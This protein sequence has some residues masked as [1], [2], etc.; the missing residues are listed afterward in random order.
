MDSE[1]ENLSKSSIRRGD[2][3]RIKFATSNPHPVHGMGTYISAIRLLAKGE[4]EL[5][6]F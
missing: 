5:E 1:G 3:L 2:T 4:V 6:D